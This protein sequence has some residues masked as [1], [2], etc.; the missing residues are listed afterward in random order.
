[1][2]LA[3]LGDERSLT[4]LDQEIKSTNTASLLEAIRKIS[5]VRNDGALTMLMQYLIRNKTNF[6]RVKIEG[7]AG[8]DPM[9]PVLKG[10]IAIVDDPPY[11]RPFFTDPD[12]LSEWEKWWKATKAPW[13]ISISSTLPGGK[14]RCLVRLAE[15][16]FAD[17]PRELFLLLG[18]ESIPALQ[19]LAK[20]GNPILGD[21]EWPTSPA[22]SVRGDAQTILAK[23]GDQEQFER[24][25]KQLD[26]PGTYR[27]AIDKFQYIASQE[28]F[29]ILLHSLSLSSF[30]KDRYY[31]PDNTLHYL[32]EK[33][34]K[35][36][37][38]ALSEMVVTPPLASNAP[39][40][41]TNIQ[42]WKEWWQANKSKDV[43]KK[44][45]F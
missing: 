4:E 40:T 35:D 36:V 24:I 30:P 45:P 15:S 16:G 23:A 8:E 39:A 32:G 33:L 43:L 13:I 5:M 6:H 37:M 31:A 26:E 28:S 17:A 20:A 18:K 11:T 10:L 44:V 27:D 42:I 41:G 14:S 2:A 1:V 22:G 7:D 9:I 21:K 29:G 38:V 3:R 34:Q 12:N 25:A 19:R